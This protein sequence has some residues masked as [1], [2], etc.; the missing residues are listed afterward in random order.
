MGAGNAIAALRDTGGKG[1]SSFARCVLVVM[2]LRSLDHKIGRN[3][4]RYFYAGHDEIAL[5]LGLDP[6][7]RELRNVRRAI[8]TLTAHGYVSDVGRVG[9]NSCYRLHLAVDKPVDEGG[10]EVRSTDPR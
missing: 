6:L 2:A 5:A 7:P 10:F 1:I 9:R 3:E 4:P 8:A